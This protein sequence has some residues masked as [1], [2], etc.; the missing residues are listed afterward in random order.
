[1][2]Y[3]G[4]STHSTGGLSSGEQPAQQPLTLE[5]GRSGGFGMVR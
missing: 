2:G 1:M 4:V 3:R 5:S